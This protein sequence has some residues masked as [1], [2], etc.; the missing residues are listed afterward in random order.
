MVTPI[1]SSIV[2]GTRETRLAVEAE[3]GDSWRSEAKRREAEA[4]YGGQGPGGCLRAVTTFMFG[5]R[6]R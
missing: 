5:S 3:A 2:T 4:G 6:Q 1:M